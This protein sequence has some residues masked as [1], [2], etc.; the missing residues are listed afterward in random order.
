[1]GPLIEFAFIPQISLS[2][3][4]LKFYSS[5]K[6]KLINLPQELYMDNMTLSCI[7]DELHEFPPFIFH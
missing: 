4:P 2:S 7:E 6:V 1:M 5:Q 3:L